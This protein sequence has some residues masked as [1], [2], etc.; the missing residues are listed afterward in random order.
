MSNYFSHKFRGKSP[1]II[2]GYVLFAIIAGLALAILFGFIIM[3][4]WN[5]LMPEIFGLNVITYWQAVG[6]FILS[7]LILGGIGGGNKNS[8]KSD[9]KCKNGT[10]KKKDFSKW[11]HYDKFWEE[12]GNKA[13]SEYVDRLNDDTN[14]ESIEE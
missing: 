14:P 13:Y 10:K 3:W 7:K 2:I 6:L 8:S 4:L 5:A 11:S 9:D 1:A 12:E